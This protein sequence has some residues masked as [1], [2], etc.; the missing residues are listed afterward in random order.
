MYFLSINL[1]LITLF[2]NVL[3]D[4]TNQL[5]VLM[6]LWSTVPR[7]FLALSIKN[8]SAVHDPMYVHTLL[9]LRVYAPCSLSPVNEG[10]RN[11]KGTGAVLKMQTTSP[12]LMEPWPNPMRPPLVLKGRRLS[13]AAPRAW[14]YSF[15]SLHPRAI[16]CFI[17][18]FHLVLQR[19]HLVS[20]Q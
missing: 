6:Q 17:E 9:P 1:F 7:Y 8:A 4:I 12:A 18:L 20:E 10:G 13:A 15:T 16:D 11:T 19:L 3:V 2:L 14:Y 5:Q